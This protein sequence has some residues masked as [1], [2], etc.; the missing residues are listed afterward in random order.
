MTKTD[1]E[2]HRECMQRF[3]DLANSMKDEG[4]APRVASAGMMLASAVYS[5]YVFAGNDGRL[6]PSGIAKLA[7]AY[8]QQLEQVQRSKEASQKK[9]GS[10]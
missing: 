1:D 10:A 4:I 7:D 8:R 2:T 3:I 6:A 5:T 9:A